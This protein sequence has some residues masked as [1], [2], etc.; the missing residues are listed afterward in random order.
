MRSLGRA[1]RSA[2]HMLCVAAH[3]RTSVEAVHLGGADVR[4]LDERGIGLLDELD[5]MPFRELDQIP[6]WSAE[7]PDRPDPL[8]HL[9]GCLIEVDVPNGWRSASPVCSKNTDSSDDRDA[10]EQVLPVSLGHL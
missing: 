10:L 9:P 2:K 5:Q 3:R 1:L 4:T 7:S 8:V 6:R